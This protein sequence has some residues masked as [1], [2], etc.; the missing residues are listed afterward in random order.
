MINDL[1]RIERKVDNVSF[2]IHRPIPLDDFN[3]EMLASTHILDIEQPC[4]T[5]L[6]PRVIQALSMKKCIITT[7]KWISSISWIKGVEFIDRENPKINNFSNIHSNGKIDDNILKLRIDKWI[8][9]LINID[10]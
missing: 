6:T 4:Q 10:K 1:D 7:N 3:K 8:L 5:A 9:N 2:I